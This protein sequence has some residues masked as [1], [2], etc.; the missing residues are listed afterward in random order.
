MAEKIGNQNDESEILSDSKKQTLKENSSKVSL[1][2]P[3]IEEVKISK[4]QK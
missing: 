3:S 4:D 1:E 2:D